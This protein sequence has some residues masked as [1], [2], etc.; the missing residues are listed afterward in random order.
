MS[1][2]KHTNIPAAVRKQEAEAEAALA[3][4]EALR[5]DEAA[6]SD[7]TSVETAANTRDTL[8]DASALQGPQPAAPTQAEPKPVEGKTA[9]EIAH[10]KLQ[11]KHDVLQGKYNSEIRRM[12][13]RL[14][15]LETQNDTL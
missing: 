4:L 2:D 10:D 15:E 12:S 5:T 3:A 14:K 8:T 11:A 7:E 6:A 9:E 13:D 1:Q